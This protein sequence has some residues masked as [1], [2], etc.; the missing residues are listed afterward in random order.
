MR[1]GSSCAG[2][3]ENTETKQGLAPETGKE[4]KEERDALISEHL[5]TKMQH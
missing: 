5:G 2:S 1:L 3:L 4:Q